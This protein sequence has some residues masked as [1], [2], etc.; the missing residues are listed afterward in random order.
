M[1]KIR[2]A[3]RPVDSAANRALIEFVAATLSV[4]K[5]SVAVVAGT[6][7]RRKLLEISGV[8]AELVARKLSAAE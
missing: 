1:V 2:I 8:S 7:H 4:P 5:R 6:S 3:A